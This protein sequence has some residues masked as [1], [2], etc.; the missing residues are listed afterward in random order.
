ML[1][2]DL[3]LGLDYFSGQYM[4]G[5][6]DDLS[7]ITFVLDDMSQ[8]RNCMYQT[9]RTI[10]KTNFSTWTICHNFTLDDLSQVIFVTILFRTISHNLTRHICPRR[11]V[12]KKECD[13][14]EILRT[15][16]GCHEF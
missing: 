11:Y 10:C 13:L 5:L 16:M 7:Q 15:W 1:L 14:G 9:I 6:L 3:E 2:L 8:K 12:T 4:Y